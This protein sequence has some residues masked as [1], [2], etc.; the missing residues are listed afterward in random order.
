MLSSKLGSR[1]SESVVA[2]SSLPA[3]GRWQL[4]QAGTLTESSRPRP[5]RP[6]TS[7]GQKGEAPSQ[8]AAEAIESDVAP[9]HQRRARQREPISAK[10]IDTMQRR[11]DMHVFPYIGSYEVGAVTGPQLL[12]VLRRVESRGPLELA[13]RLRSI[14]G[15]VFRYAKAT[16][17]SSDRRP[18]P[19]RT[20]CIV[21]ALPDPKML[22]EVECIARLGGHALRKP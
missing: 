8:A 6:C 21:A 16:V 1:N 22:V 3:N 9:C 15:R 4:G 10:T 11:L 2:F 17:S 19:A 5:V 12:E 20:T 7:K 14:C 13:H 18:Y